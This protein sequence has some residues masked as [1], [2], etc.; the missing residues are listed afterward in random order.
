LIRFLSFQQYSS[1]S[2]KRVLFN[3]VDTKKW[4]LIHYGCWGLTVTIAMNPWTQGAVGNWMH[5]PTVDA[6][7]IVSALKKLSQIPSSIQ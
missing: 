1:E 5:L 2:L 4:A 6:K 3:N 7:Y